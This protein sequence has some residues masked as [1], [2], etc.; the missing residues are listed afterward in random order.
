M[1]EHSVA[2]AVASRKPS[3][4]GRAYH[5]RSFYGPVGKF[6]TVKASNFN[7]SHHFKSGYENKALDRRYFRPNSDAGRD[8]FAVELLLSSVPFD[9]V[10]LLLAHDLST[11]V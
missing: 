9:Q 10:S 3:L 7:K 6:V 11:N 2:T 1:P 5:P 4:S 8:T